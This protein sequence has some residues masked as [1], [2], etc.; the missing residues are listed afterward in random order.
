M[1]TMEWIGYGFGAL[2]MLTGF[3]TLQ[4]K[5]A[6]KM[7]L[8]YVALCALFGLHYWCLGA[9]AGFVMNMVGAVRNLF[10]YFGNDYKFLQ[11]KFVPIGF[12]VLVGVLGFISRESVYAYLMIAGLVINSFCLSFK[13]TQNIRKSILVTSPMVLAYA[14]L[15]GSIFGV[16]YESIA[17]LSAVLGI[18]RHKQK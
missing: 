4:I 8:W 18:V 10:Y 2:A 17:I 13:N 1:T 3:L 11:K 7:L 15:S 12:T 6:K 16:I 14:A 9:T 5:D